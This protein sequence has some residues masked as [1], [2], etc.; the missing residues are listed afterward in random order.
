MKPLA[1]AADT[2]RLRKATAKRV[3]RI[4]RWAQPIRY[5]YYQAVIGAGGVGLVCA[6][7]CR[8]EGH[9]VVVF[10]KGERIGGTWLVDRAPDN[11]SELSRM[12]VLAFSIAVNA[13]CDSPGQRRK[14][15]LSRSA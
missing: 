6:K 8:R 2:E 10:E 4:S 1:T 9:R 11:L 13:L 14:G 12:R 5:P 7:E 15:A 3:V